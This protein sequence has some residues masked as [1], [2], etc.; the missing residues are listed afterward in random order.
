MIGNLHSLCLWCGGFCELKKKKEGRAG[1]LYF[2]SESFEKET[3]CKKFGF[4]VCLLTRLL[5]PKTTGSSVYCILNEK[6]CFFTGNLKIDRQSWVERA[7]AFLLS[8]ERERE[9]VNFLLKLS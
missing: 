1:C 7:S 5:N 6:D 2:E 9:R 3:L 4:L 8:F